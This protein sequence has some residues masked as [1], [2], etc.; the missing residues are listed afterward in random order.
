MMF[1]LREYNQEFYVEKTKSS[2]SISSRVFVVMFAF[3]L[4]GF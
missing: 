4:I 2:H 1:N 3:K